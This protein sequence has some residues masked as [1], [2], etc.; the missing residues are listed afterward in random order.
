MN[1]I[2]ITGERGVPEHISR[3][4]LKQDKIKETI[5]HG[6]E[7]VISHGQFTLIVVVVVLL[8]ALGYGG[9]RFYIDRQTVEA[10]IAFDSAM[11]AYQGRVGVAPDPALPNEPVYPNEA[12]RAQDAS[13]KFASVA[14]KY[15]K[16]NP[17]K[18]ARYYY[19]LTLEDL[20]RHN[21]ALEELKRL[22]AGSDKELAAMAQYQMA[23][24]YSR[25]GKPDEAAKIFRALADKPTVLVPRPLVLLE[26]A[27]VLRT[28]KPQEAASVYQQLKKEFP[29]TAIAEAADRGL[30]ALSPKS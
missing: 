29:D 18:L 22:S 1:S 9:W 12:A 14:D 30:D 11:K 2:C 24:I 20:E 28:T 21:Q 5:E 26:L 15:P 13:V 7:A 16:T 6:A 19:A 10:S 17:G 25:I 8:V 23:V 4:E 3:K 27:G